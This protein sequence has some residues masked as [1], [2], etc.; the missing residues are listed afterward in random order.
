MHR[1]GRGE[2]PLS[3]AAETLAAWRVEIEER[4]EA[5]GTFA[6]DCLSTGSL[7]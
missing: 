1:P 5:L 6:A 4:A 7:F 2:R 3:G